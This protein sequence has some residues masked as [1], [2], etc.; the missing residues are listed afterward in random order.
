M[1]KKY[2]RIL[3]PVDGSK[4]AELALKKSIAIAL[5]NDASL[6]ICHVVDTRSI[7]TSTGYEGILSD[8]LVDQAKSLLADYKKYAEER[9]VK[10]VKTIIDYGSPKIQIAFKLSKENNIDLIMI[11]AT[12][13]NAVERLFIGSVSEYVIRNA[14]CDVLVVRTNLENIE[15]DD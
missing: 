12:G 5:Q 2:E 15:E 6:I 1:Y 10:E 4:E 7:Q 13:L 3:D 9:G 8:E 14:N 11:G